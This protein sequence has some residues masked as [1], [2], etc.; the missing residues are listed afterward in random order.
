M[1]PSARPIDLCLINSP[2]PYLV[3]PHAQAP[4]GLLYLAAVAE[5]AGLLVR[6]VNLAAYQVGESC[7]VPP[8]LAYGITGTSLDIEAVNDLAAGIK[9]RIPA[10]LVIVGG[11]IS[12]SP[13]QLTTD[14][15]I[16]VHGE[17]ESVIVELCRGGASPPAPFVE[18][19]P[20]AELDSLPLPA[21]H[22]WAGPFGGDI[23]LGHRRYFPGGSATITTSRGCPFACAFCAGPALSSRRVRFHSAER[24][25]EEMERCVLDFGVRQFR[26]SDEF[27]TARAA[28]ALGVCAA[29][30]ASKR[31]GH[32]RKIAWRASIGVNP[33]GPELFRAMAAA[34]CREVSF[35]VETADP[36]ILALVSNKGAV[37]H[38]WAACKNARAAGLGVRALLMVGLP[39]TT[40]KTGAD[41][42]RFIAEAAADA[43]AVTVFTPLPGSAIAANPGEY[44]CEILPARARSSLCIFGPAGANE[45]RP[46]IRVPGMNDAELTR[47]M[48]ETITQAEASGKL[49]HG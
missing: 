33:H 36:K 16:V 12:L 30:R 19:R 40:R 1:N 6:L 27:F 26:L 45:I 34:G 25:V 8:A 29:I 48:R 43:I 23:F 5:E 14:V 11:P 31:L 49:G 7:S 38:A 44:G 9:A 28:H 37:E 15:D 32:G 17:G 47:Q 39:G 3:A 41:N 21:R 18:G 42:E 35:G 10:A 22:L 2:H 4:L 20:V 24:I 13:E 46:T